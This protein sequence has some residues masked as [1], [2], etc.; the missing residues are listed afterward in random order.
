MWYSHP[1]YTDYSCDEEGNI[2]N[3]RTGRTVKQTHRGDGYL[4]FSLRVERN[5]KK[6]YASHRFILECLNGELIPKGF[7]TDHINANR[8]DNSAQNLRLTTPRG[9]SRNPHYLKLRREIASRKGRKRNIPIV[10]TYKAIPI[11][12]YDSMRDAARSNGIPFSTLWCR[13]V[14]GTVINEIEYVPVID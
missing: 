3:T 8:S 2:R 12:R 4:A 5:V 7:Q 6:T 13:V 1:V 10:V 14:N 11:A 9:N